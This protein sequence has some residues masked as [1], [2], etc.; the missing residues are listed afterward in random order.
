[1]QRKIHLKRT[2]S[3]PT[4]AL[5]ILTLFTAFYLPKALA[6]VAITQIS[7]VQG[8][9]GTVVTVTGQITTQNGSYKVFF[10]GKERASGNAI[11]TSVSATLTVPNSTSGEQPI[12]L[13]D[14]T[15][16]EFYIARTFIVQTSYAVKAVAPQPPEQAQEGANVT[17]IATILGGNSTTLVNLTV[18]DPNNDVIHSAINVSIPIQDGFG[19]ANRTYPTDFSQNATTY[20]VGSYRMELNIADETQTTG[21]FTVGLTNAT[22]YHR[23]QTVFIQAA[24]Y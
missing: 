18:T 6:E 3:F 11:Q 2:A 5:L 10:G 23:F 7:P 17:I 20:Y 12:E 15:T 1:M 8:P 19:A 14:M 21:S 22:E 13:R 24:N 4:I 9:V 16:G